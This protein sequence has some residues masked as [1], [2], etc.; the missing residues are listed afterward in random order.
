MFDQ[1]THSENV[2]RLFLADQYADCIQEIQRAVALLGSAQLREIYILI[3][4][5]GRVGTPESIESV[6]GRVRP[7]IERFPFQLALLDLICDKTK[8]ESVI[9]LA[10]SDEQRGEAYF[11]AGEVAFTNR[12]LGIAIG[13]FGECLNIGLS[14]CFFK[15]AQVE[16]A[17]ARSQMLAWFRGQIGIR[18]G[19]LASASRDGCHKYTEIPSSLATLAREVLEMLVGDDF[20]STIAS[21]VRLILAN[22]Y[23]AAIPMLELGVQTFRSSPRPHDALLD[24]T[25]RIL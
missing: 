23:A 12:D 16:Q 15:M 1:I 2:Q 10:E 20:D 19:A 21:G 5:L 24:A 25:D 11:Y 14:D 4:C 7:W 13:F 8:I 18:V 17:K 9:R 3:L 6:R 22:E